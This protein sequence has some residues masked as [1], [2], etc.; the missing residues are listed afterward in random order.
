M[1]CSIRSLEF[2]SIVACPCKVNKSE[3]FIY[4]FLKQ[5]S[6]QVGYKP[7]HTEKKGTIGRSTNMGP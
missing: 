4:L 2:V 7:L 5:I 1:I 6:T 3:A